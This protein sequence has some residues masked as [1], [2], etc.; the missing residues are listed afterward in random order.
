MEPKDLLPCSQ[1]PAR[2]S[3]VKHYA[4]ELICPVIFS[5]VELLV[6]KMYPVG[7][8]K[9]SDAVRIPVA[10]NPASVP[11]VPVVFFMNDSRPLYYIYFRVLTHIS[12]YC[13]TCVRSN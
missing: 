11:R 4:S 12:E 3:L 7:H 2:G 10:W 8:S 13:Q 1:E 5:T 9:V 6:I